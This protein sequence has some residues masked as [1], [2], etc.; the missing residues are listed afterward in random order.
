MASVKVF[1]YPGA[2]SRVT[3]SALEEA[4]VPYVDRWIDITGSVANLF[5]D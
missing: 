2:C 1:S 3:M 4:G 5:D